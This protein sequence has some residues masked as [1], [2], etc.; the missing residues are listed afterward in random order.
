MKFLMKN[1]FSDE[2]RMSKKI[3]GLLAATMIAPIGV[4]TA[5][6]ARAADADGYSA[7]YAGIGLDVTMPQHDKVKGGATGELKYSTSVT[8]PD[9]VVGW[10]PQGLYGETGDARFE[11]GLL[12]RGFG[13][14][15]AING[16]TT[17]KPGGG[18]ALA[19]LMTSAY[20]D[21]HTASS[22][23]PFVGAGVG[24]A[25]ARFSKNPGFG[26]TD[27]TSNNAM[28]AYHLTAGVSY[29]PQ[30][31]PHIDFSL[32]YD[33]LGTTRPQFDTGSGSGRVRLDALRANS[34]EAGFKYHF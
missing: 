2:V 10:R 4:A 7:W 28:F 19:A 27:K 18:L 13:V 5:G 33:W 6:A 25:A 1:G 20:Y 17:S 32:A 8:L 30:A 14:H 9:L 22:F 34:V 16:S 29:T 26:I 11:L 24:M 15:Q 21:F 12:S 3:L 31:W 23:T